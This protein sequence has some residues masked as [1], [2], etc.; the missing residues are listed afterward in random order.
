[1]SRR[2]LQAL[3]L[4]AAISLAGCATTPSEPS[5]DP[6]NGFSIDCGPISMLGSCREAI[7]V[8]GRAQWQADHRISFVD[9]SA[10]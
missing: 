8:R 4:V 7:A 2:A 9:S 10:R 6:S 5:E 3:A 1:M